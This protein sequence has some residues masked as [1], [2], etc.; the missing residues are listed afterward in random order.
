MMCLSPPHF[1]LFVCTADSIC[2][3]LLL[4]GLCISS[5]NFRVADV[6]L[7]RMHK[8]SFG[9]WMCFHSWSYGPQH[10]HTEPCALLL[11]T[12]KPVLDFLQSYP[13]TRA[14][15]CSS[16]HAGW[17][18]NKALPFCCQGNMA[19]SNQSS[20]SPVPGR[21]LRTSST[22]RAVSVPLSI[23]VSV[24]TF[25]PLNFLVNVTVQSLESETNTLW[26]MIMFLSVKITLCLLIY[27][28]S[29]DQQIHEWLI[30]ITVYN[31]LL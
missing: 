27:C 11:P 5:I 18:S 1:F 8:P 22:L 25:P 21:A 23:L 2:E 19:G 10:N 7:C 28:Q 6:P 13:H 20:V 4:S 14:H 29:C 17:R 12:Q 31:S 30:S 24:S 16:P 26:R 3:A 9:S 15:A